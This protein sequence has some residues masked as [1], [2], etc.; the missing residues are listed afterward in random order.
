MIL[1]VGVFAGLS[2]ACSAAAMS[3]PAPATKA[4]VNGLQVS[5]GLLLLSVTAATSLAEERARGSMDLIL[6]TPLSTKQI[7]MGKWLGAY[8]VVPLLAILPT[9]VIASGAIRVHWLH[10]LLALLMIVYVLSAGAA[11]TSL[12]LAMATVFPRL[13]RAVGVTVAI[14]VFVAAGFFA[15]VTLLA[16]GARDRSLAMGSPFFWAGEMSFEASNQRGGAPVGWAVA[17]TIFCVWIAVQL[18]RFTLRQFDRRLGRVE[19]PVARMPGSTRGARLLTKIYLCVLVATFVMS[20]S[21]SWAPVAVAFQFGLGVLFLAMTSALVSR[22]DEDDQ[23]ASDAVPP[24]NRVWPG[25]LWRWAKAH[26]AVLP[27]LVPAL[28]VIMLQAPSE[29]FWGKLF[30]L[31]LYM[32]AVGAALISLGVVF[33]QTRMRRGWMIMTLTLAWGVL[34]LSW[35]VMQGAL[36]GDLRGGA[37]ALGMGSP[38]IGVSSLAGSII[39]VR[40]GPDEAIGWAFWWAIIYSLAALSLFR[41]VSVKSRGAD[42]VVIPRTSL[43]QATTNG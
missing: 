40:G 14:Y 4:W 28:I 34:N 12:G 33:A 26:R 39:H 1:I 6:S 37:L 10:S 15:L 11:I 13:G 38:V 2:L 22:R 17:W 23:A 24:P 32:L 29:G 36:E 30:V 21:S 42:A 3:L 8:R 43:S 19:L 5:I 9:L 35:I 27:V 20:L 18:L 16:G 41:R 7:V 25:V 31:S